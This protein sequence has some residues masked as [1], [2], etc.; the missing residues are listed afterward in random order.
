MW[1]KTYLSESS[2]LLPSV[3]G[4]DLRKLSQ[5]PALTSG[6]QIFIASVLSAILYSVIYLVLR[7]TL[8]IKGG[9]TL[10]LDPHERWAVGGVNQDYHRF[11]ARIARSMLW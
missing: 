7:G 1:H 4:Q 10:I 8:N 5:F 11:I 2:V 3:S 6:A 9:V